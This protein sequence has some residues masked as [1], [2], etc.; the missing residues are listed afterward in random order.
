MKE[1]RI[2]R[3]DHRN[4]AIQSNVGKEWRT[5]S[6]HGNSINS[7]ISGL[8]ELIGSKCNVDS[9]SL[10]SAVYELDKTV[11]NSMVEIE[12]MINEADK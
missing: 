3:I 1:Y 2:R 8:L 11:K 6:Y 4:I 7:L 5:V 12:R 9:E 10:V